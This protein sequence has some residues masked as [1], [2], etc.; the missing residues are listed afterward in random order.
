MNRVGTRAPIAGLL[1]VALLSLV[2]GCDD[3]QGPRPGI[4]ILNVV[5]GSAEVEEARVELDGQ[6]V[7]LTC[8]SCSS[9]LDIAG[10][11]YDMRVSDAGDPSVQV[12]ASIFVDG[13]EEYHAI[14][15]GAASDLSLFLVRNDNEPDDGGGTERFH[16][17]HAAPLLGPI[18]VYLTAQGVP[19]E[20]V[21]PIKV[22]LAFKQTWYAPV[23]TTDI[24]VRVTTQGS[25]VSLTDSQFL[26]GGH[27]F[28]LF[29]PPTFLFRLL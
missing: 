9:G 6:V 7:A 21:D 24:E 26:T 8:Y 3:A 13:G 28:I 16:V 22:G 29:G 10:D 17:I 20:S 19:L 12:T 4:A 1:L 27:T 23:S 15:T 2:W 11:R 25:K 18:D 5:N 14:L